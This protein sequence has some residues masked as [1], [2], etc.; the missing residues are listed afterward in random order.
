MN[1]YLS[2]LYASDIKDLELEAINN[3][4]DDEDDY[5]P[6]VCCPDG[7][8]EDEARNEGYTGGTL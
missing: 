5:S 7:Y 8:G 2:E 3:R 6:V 4:P 1:D